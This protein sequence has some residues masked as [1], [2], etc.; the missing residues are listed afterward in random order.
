[1]RKPKYQF[2]SLEEYQRRLEALRSRMERKGVDGMLVTIPEN[3][4]YLTGYETP[5]YY[6][7]QTLVVPMDR[8]PVFITRLGEATNVEPLS[9]VEDSR[10]Y[11]DTQDW[12]AKTKDTL[13]DLG[14]VGQR[15]G[16]EYRSWFITI[17][18][19]LRLSAV[20][21]DTRFVDC[22]GLVEQGRMIKSPQEI[23]YMRQAA[24]A[25]EAGIRAGVEASAV[26]ATEN[27]VAAEVHRAQILAGSE[28]TGLPI[29]VSSGERA[30]MTHATWYRRRLE[31]SDM[32]HMEIPGCV[33][34]YH[35]AKWAQVYLGDPPKQ[36]V[37]A[38]EAA[39]KITG[40][41]SP[42]SRRG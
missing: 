35:A 17:E 1:M 12:I 33:N 15:I 14:L 24:R 28:Y 5:G 32:V 26:G 40:P 31:P 38:F 29:F 4:Y 21:P 27:E 16:L 42:S 7:F 30:D 18:D 36:V 41:S 10:P 37:S 9:W 25:A 11:D 39:I 6:W 20:L 2:F 19:Y 8:E 34:R 3:L 13:A 22:S 23:E